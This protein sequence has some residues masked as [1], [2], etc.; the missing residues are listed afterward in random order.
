MIYNNSYKT[1]IGAKIIKI[2]DLSFNILSDKKPYENIFY[3]ILI[4]WQFLQNF[5]G[6][7]TF[8]G[9]K[10]LCII[11]STVDE[12]IRDY[13]VTKYLVLLGSEKY[14]PVYNRIRYLLGKKRY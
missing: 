2:E 3:Y 11:Y 4:F 5:Y 1:L 6:Y 14:D 9:T 10:P 13:D 12:F 7:K 8:M